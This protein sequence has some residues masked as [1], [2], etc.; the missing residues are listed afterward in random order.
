MEEK[1]F[2]EKQADLKR[3]LLY[4]RITFFPAAILNLIFILQESRYPP[5]GMAIV[6]PLLLVSL[7]FSLK[8]NSL[9]KQLA[10]EQKSA[11]QK[12]VPQI[13]EDDI[14]E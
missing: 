3:M 5:W 14:W 10:T 9:K 8:Y 13:A 4:Y 2:E 6:L 11:E 7:I 12:V 1:S